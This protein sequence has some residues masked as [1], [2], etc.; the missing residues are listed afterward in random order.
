MFGI[1]KFKR[2]R[3]YDIVYNALKAAKI[4]SE[5]KAQQSIKQTIENG[6]SATILLTLI[7]AILLLVFPGIRSMLIAISLI[8]LGWIWASVYNGKKQINRFV[9]E[10]ILNKKS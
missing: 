1:L 7:S 4:D 2:Q 6:K 10:E 3:N 9:K 5:E 8:L